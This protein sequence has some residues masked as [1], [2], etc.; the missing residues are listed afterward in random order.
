MQSYV[1]LFIAQCLLSCRWSGL[2]AQRLVKTSVMSSTSESKSQNSFVTQNF[3]KYS[4]LY[5][6]QLYDN[7]VFNTAAPAHR[8]SQARDHRRWCS[9]AEIELPAGIPP[10]SGPPELQG[11]SDVLASPSSGNSVISPAA[12]SSGDAIPSYNSQQARGGR[13]QNV[14]VDNLSAPLT[15]FGNSVPTFNSINNI[16]R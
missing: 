6:H 10:A 9:H 3:S 16:I 2:S 12:P 15:T 14:G 8:P 1:S 5:H 13:S 11:G 7:E 4:N